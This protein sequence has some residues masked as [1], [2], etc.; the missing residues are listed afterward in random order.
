METEAVRGAEL[1][2][3]VGGIVGC[4]CAGEKEKNSSVA[5][6]NRL[7][8]TSDSAFSFRRPHDPII[9]THTTH[10]CISLL[11]EIQ[12]DAHTPTHT[13]IINPSGV[14]FCSINIRST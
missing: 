3:G 2:G 13:C 7:G 8:H 9:L 5:D 6:R 11:D 12:A 4:L 1:G 10:I 14:F